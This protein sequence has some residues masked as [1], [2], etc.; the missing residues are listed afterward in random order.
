VI[1]FRN[2]RISPD[3]KTCDMSDRSKIAAG[4]GYLLSEKKGS[5]DILSTN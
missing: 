5:R 3:Q 1:A 4:S 2:P